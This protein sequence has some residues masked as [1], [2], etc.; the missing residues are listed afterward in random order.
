M[1]QIIMAAAAIL[2]FAA[3]AMAGGDSFCDYSAKAKVAYKGKAK[4]N[5]EAKAK[6]AAKDE[7]LK[8]I[9]SSRK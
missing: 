8:I 7:A 9:A 1:K 3:P 2:I 4:I 6:D 5:I